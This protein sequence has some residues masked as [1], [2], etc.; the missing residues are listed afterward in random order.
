MAVYGLDIFTAV[1]MISSERVRLITTQRILA[2][3]FQWTNAITAKGS[4]G[5]V[6]VKFIIAK[7]VFV[8]CIIFSFLLVSLLLPYT[9][10]ILIVQLGYETFKARQV[11]KSRDISYAFTNVLANDYFS[12]SEFPVPQSPRAMTAHDLQRAMT[13]SA[14][15]VISMNL[16][17]RRMISPFSSSSLSRVSLPAFQPILL[18]SLLTLHR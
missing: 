17:R 10:S 12:F 13:I 16:P 15:F 5:I 18:S 14:Y 6:E 11:I 1:T 7:W 8:G 2:L 9:L 4:E 3:T